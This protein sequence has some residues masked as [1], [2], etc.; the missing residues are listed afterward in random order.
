VEAAREAEGDAEDRVG[1]LDDPAERVVHDFLDHVVVLTHSLVRGAELVVGEPSLALLQVLTALP[2]GFFLF[3]KQKRKN[4]RKM[5][6]GAAPPEF[7]RQESDPLGA[8]PSDQKYR[9]SLHESAPYMEY[10]RATGAEPP[11]LRG[12]LLGVRNRA[13]C[14][15]L[16]GTAK[17]EKRAFVRLGGV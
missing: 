16:D 9:D 11:P 12:R 3:P 6:W 17:E 4:Q 8:A 7:G 10:L 2:A 1:V 5:L 14:V 13:R 15:R